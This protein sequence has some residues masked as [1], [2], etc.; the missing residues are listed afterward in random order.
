MNEQGGRQH[1]SGRNLSKDY[2]GSWLMIPFVLLAFLFVILAGILWWP[3]SSETTNLETSAP[4]VEGPNAPQ[5]AIP[6]PSKTP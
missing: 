1:R 6:A 3:G 4:H 5:P 2:D